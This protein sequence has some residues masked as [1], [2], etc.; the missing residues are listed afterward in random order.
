MEEQRVVPGNHN[1]EQVLI[2][3]EDTKEGLDITGSISALSITESLD[4]PGMQCEILAADIADVLGRLP[5][6]GH[7]RVIVTWLSSTYRELE[8]EERQ[9]AFRITNITN[10]NPKIDTVETSYRISCVSEFVYHDQFYGID[11]G[12][13][14]TCSDLIE[15][16]HNVI[17]DDVGDILPDKKFPLPDK[18]A[19]ASKDPTDGLNK[20]AGTGDSPLK[21][22]ELLTSWSFSNEF[23]SSTYFYFQN[24]NGYNFR[25]IES[26]SK[27]WADK[28]LDSEDM[29]IRTY[30][31][32]NKPDTDITTGENYNISALVIRKRGDSYKN[33]ISGRYNN[34]VNELDYL[35]KRV[36][37]FDFVYNNEYGTYQ[38]FNSRSLAS[39]TFLSSYGNVSTQSH[40]VFHG[41]DK[42]QDLPKALNHKWSFYQLAGDLTI[43]ATVMGNSELTCGECIYINMPS[44]DTVNSQ[45]D[46]QEDEVMSGYYLIKDCVHSFNQGT[47][48]TQLTLIRA[49]SE[50]LQNE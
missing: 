39:D 1:L 28:G 5:V 50:N 23:K 19:I 36:D 30:T 20:Y 27:E 4:L 18:Y 11:E 35:K 13:E 43:S 16:C 47:Y 37:V 33:A 9:E 10:V 32:G 14:G 17:K 46:L 26:L 48:I 22:I 7:E 49:G 34:R 15:T 40:W 29:S 41:T 2:V 12:L 8:A 25:N 21:T 44:R 45:E 6:I 31:Y 38:M 24:K 3:S 42:V